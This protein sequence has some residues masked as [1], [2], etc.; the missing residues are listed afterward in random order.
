MAAS[1]EPW[2]LGCRVFLDVHF[3]SNLVRNC[4]H[5][6]VISPMAAVLQDVLREKISVYTYIHIQIYTYTA[7]S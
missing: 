3:A 7:T 6:Q 2:V 5:D 4:K 1:F